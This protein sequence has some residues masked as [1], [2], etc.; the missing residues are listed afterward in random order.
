MGSGEPPVKPLK[1]EIAYAT[2]WFQIAG[3]TMREGE[4]PYYSLRLPDY[5]AV[6]AITEEQR[7]CYRAPV[8]SGGGAPHAGTAERP[9][10]SRRDS[11][12]S[13]R[14]ANCW[15]RPATRP[16]R[17]NCSVRWT[18]TSAAWAIASGAA[19][20]NVV[21]RIEG[22]APEEGIEVLEWSLDELYR[23]I[24][25]GTLRSCPSCRDHLPSGAE[26]EA[27]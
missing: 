1:V 6:V 22:R 15:K 27:V 26:G 10:R 16:A 24:E 23:A 7:V 2:P 11:R 18:R 14:A 20:R 8:P 3:K 9:R 17:W 25:D 21:R 5:A 19:S 13:R 12:R 4:E